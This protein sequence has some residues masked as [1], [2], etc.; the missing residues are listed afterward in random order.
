MKG[1][2]E[3]GVGVSTAVG[4]RHLQV[5]EAQKNPLARAVLYPASV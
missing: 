5:V 3:R 2:K 4:G 1:H